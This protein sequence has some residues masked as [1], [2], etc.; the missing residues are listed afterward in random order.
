MAASVLPFQDI[1]VAGDVASSDATNVDTAMTNLFNK[2]K[3]ARAL[4]NARDATWGGTSTETEGAWMTSIQAD[5][6]NFVSTRVSVSAGHY[7]VVSPIDGSNYRRPLSWLAAVRDA[8]VSLA[9][10]LGQ[11][12]TG[13][14]FPM[15]VPS[16]PLYFGGGSVPFIYHNE[17]VNPGLDASR[18]LSAQQYTGFPGFY[19]VNPNLMA[20]PGS[21]FT[22]LQRGH[23]VDEASFIAYVYFTLQLAK[24][25]RV[26]STTGFILTQ[27]A[28]TLEQ[29]CNAQLNA[30]MVSPG[31]VSSAACN[32]TRN[33]NILSTNTLIAT[34]NIVPLAYPK[35]ISVTIQYVNPAVQPV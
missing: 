16:S 2:R 9:T 29:G 17:A 4:T 15:T 34:I 35:T 3:Y 5:F 31:F 7:N 12:S 32:V 27:D 24:A 8:Q 30:Q 20:G 6:I 18:F 28:N 13:P 23:V 11:V 14:L 1:V 19:I 10:D 25:V 26:N 33:N 22:W 21:D